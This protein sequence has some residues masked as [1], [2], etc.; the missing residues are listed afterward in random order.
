MRQSESRA[1]CFL[2]DRIMDQIL[3]LCEKHCPAPHGR[4]RERAETRKSLYLQ[5]EIDIMN[6]QNIIV[7]VIG[8]A[9]FAWLVRAAVRSVRTRK[10]TQCDACGDAVC[11]YRVRKKEEDRR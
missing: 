8:A 7:Y 2:S 9:V 3:S 4:G 10:Y 6:W 11:P 1:A 5:Q